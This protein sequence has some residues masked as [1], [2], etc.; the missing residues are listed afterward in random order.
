MPAIASSVTPLALLLLAL[1]TTTLDAQDPPAA[2]AGQGAEQ[3]RVFLD[4]RRCDTDYLRTEIRFVDYVRERTDADVHILVTTQ[5]TGAGGQEYTFQFT[6]QRQFEGVGEDLRFTSGP[7]DSEDVVRQGIARVLRAGLVRYAARTPLLERLQLSFSTPAVGAAG[8]SVPGRDPW[9]RWVFRTS[10]SG[11]GNGEASYEQRSWSLSVSA[12]R[13][14]ADWK[15]VLSISTRSSLSDFEVG[16]RTVRNEQSDR[17]GSI[18]SVRSVSDHWSVG[19]RTNANRSSFL[20]RD[21]A[22]RVAPAIE[23]NVFPYSESTRRQLTLQYSAGANRVAYNDET[24]YGQLT[25][26]L[27]DQ[28][29]T[30]SYN[31]TQRWGTVRVSSEALHYFHDPSKYHLTSFGN[32]DLRLIKGVS[33]TFFGGVDRIR[34]QLHLAKGNLTPEQILLRQRQIATSF[35]YFG[36]VGLSYSFGSIFSS[37]VNPRM[38]NSGGGGMIFF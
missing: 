35:R 20:N 12:N 21:L 30:A 29:L 1:T 5:Q 32:L 17:T 26:T 25:E 19:G 4:C 37:V 27:W 28:A 9:N 10:L 16:D 22:L 18:L 38:G 31:M 14:T 7:T 8:A 2:P 13:T 34:D 33:L 6:G 23:F 11:F 24:I 3:L 36:Q 15:N